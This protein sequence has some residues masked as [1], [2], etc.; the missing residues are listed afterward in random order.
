MGVADS[1]TRAD[2]GCFDW[3]PGIR[4]PCAYPVGGGVPEEW[5]GLPWRSAKARSRARTGGDP[6]GLFITLVGR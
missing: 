3:A 2:R 5:A 1:G 6:A 4:R